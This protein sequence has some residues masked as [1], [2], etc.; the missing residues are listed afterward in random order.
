MAAVSLLAE[1]RPTIERAVQL[2][3]TDKKSQGLDSTAHKKHYS[4]LTPSN[5]KAQKHGTKWHQKRHQIG[6]A[7]IWK[8]N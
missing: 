8:P 2:F 4:R 6:D 3:L 7:V 1:S 5:K